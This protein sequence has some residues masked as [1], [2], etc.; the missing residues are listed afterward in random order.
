MNQIGYYGNIRSQIR[1]AD[2]HYLDRWPRD[3]VPFL[4]DGWN[5]ICTIVFNASEFESVSLDERTLNQACILNAPPIDQ[6]VVVLVLTTD[7]R[8]EAGRLTSPIIKEMPR[9]ASGSVVVTAAPIPHNPSL[10]VAIDTDSRGFGWQAPGRKGSDE[11]YGF[12]CAIGPFPRFTEYSSRRHL[13]PPLVRNLPNSLAEIRPW[14]DAPEHFAGSEIFCGVVACDSRTAILYIDDRAHCNHDHLISD[15]ND[16]ITAVRTNNV[17]PQWVL[18][19]NGLLAT[20]IT[21]AAT[22]D[23]AGVTGYL[24]NP[25]K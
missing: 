6:D 20:G 21:M 16:L 18:L 7:N 2:K 12:V 4:V 23:S 25:L 11:P 14:T 3:N 22:A 5:I 1:A 10:L 24:P 8:N 15:A 17:D 19:P 13:P 9:G